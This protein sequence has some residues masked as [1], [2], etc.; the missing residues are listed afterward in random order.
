[1]WIKFNPN[2]VGNHVEDCVQRAMSAALDIS[3][4]DASDIVH[5]M[6]TIKV[7]NERLY[8]GVM[9]KLQ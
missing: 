7:M 6:S 3:W 9:R 2:P 4:D 8:N 1:M 5:V